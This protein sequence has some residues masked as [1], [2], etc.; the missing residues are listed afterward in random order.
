MPNAFSYQ[1]PLEYN[2]G[3]D[4]YIDLMALFLNSLAAT[5]LVLVP[6]LLIVARW[7]GYRLTRVADA[8][9]EER[10]K[11]TAQFHNLDRLIEQT[12]A[13]T[14]TTQ[15]I[16]SQISGD[17]WLKQQRWLKRLDVY[18]EVLKRLE[19]LRQAAETIVEQG[20][21]KELL[22]SYGSKQSELFYVV[23]LFRLVC[24]D[25]AVAVFNEVGASLDDDGTAAYSAQIKRLYDITSRLVAI[26][27][28]DLGY[29]TE[30][31]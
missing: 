11:I 31:R 29:A 3:T 25:R 14:A 19:A 30:S 12:K 6:G 9:G 1:Q 28:E 26:A 16:K 17:L 4:V 5:L 2:A 21:Q 22:S 18:V 20:A 13:L 7:L 15:E 24:S 8:Y 10:A 27:R 23:D